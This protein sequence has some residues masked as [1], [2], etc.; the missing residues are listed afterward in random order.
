M[1]KGKTM[2]K[3]GLVILLGILLFNASCITVNMNEPEEESASAETTTEV[4]SEPVSTDE[5]QGKG[6]GEEE[7]VIVDATSAIQAD[8]DMLV[9]GLDRSIAT[10]VGDKIWEITGESYLALP[11]DSLPSGY[12]RVFDIAKGTLTLQFDTASQTVI[13]R[14]FENGVEIGMAVVPYT[15]SGNTYITAFERTETI[16]GAER[17]KYSIFFISDGKLYECEAI[18]GIDSSNYLAY[19]AVDKVTEAANTQDAIDTIVAGLDRDIANS[20]GNSVWLSNGNAVRALSNIDLP[21]GYP[22]YFEIEP[23]AVSYTF[24]TAN[25]TLTLIQYENGQEVSRTTVPYEYS[26]NTYITAF[27]RSQNL[28]GETREMMSVF[29]IWH[30]AQFLESRLR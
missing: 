22:R 21:D 30:T 26:G 25:Q 14:N 7:A 24:N 12:P 16:D 10:S 17:N 28:C 18:D 2:K 8:I 27:K 6:S 11:N 5:Q 4:T 9:A 3:T 1:R 15:Y 29:F 19:A 13:W 20:V 23:N